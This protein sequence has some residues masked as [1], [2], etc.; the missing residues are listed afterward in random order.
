MNQDDVL[1]LLLGK[2]GGGAECRRGDYQG[3]KHSL[4]SGLHRVDKVEGSALQGARTRPGAS[5]QES[6]SG[7]G[8]SKQ[9][10]AMAMRQ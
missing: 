1:R 6:G 10:S 3:R 8:M 2:R 7:T 9:F 4:H 5:G